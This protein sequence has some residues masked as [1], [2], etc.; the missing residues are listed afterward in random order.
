MPLAGAVGHTRPVA[1][2][3][4]SLLPAGVPYPE[5]ITTSG[6]QRLA[7]WPA[8][9]R[10]RVGCQSGGQSTRGTYQSMHRPLHRAC[11]WHVIITPTAAITCRPPTCPSTTGA[12]QQT[13]SMSHIQTAA[14]AHRQ[15]HMNLN[16]A[17][18]Q[19]S[20]HSIQPSFDPA[21]TRSSHHSI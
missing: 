2:L 19:P 5:R 20:H 9:A 17:V 3:C 11:G 8:I 15:T 12:A 18:T 1:S 7:T 13:G 21:I 4:E 10:L 14:L 16:P 6:S